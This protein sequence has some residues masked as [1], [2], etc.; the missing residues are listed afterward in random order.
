MRLSY[1][2]RKEGYTVRICSWPEYL[3][4]FSMDE[5]SSVDGNP[6]VD[7][8]A[9]RRLK[10]F[11]GV[12]KREFTKAVNRLTEVIKVDEDESFT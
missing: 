9:I 10:K 2:A 8:E 7:G 1:V 5:R 11:R 6:G 3:S 12:A 4:C